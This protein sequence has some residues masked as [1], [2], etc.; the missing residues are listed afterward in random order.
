[1][2]PALALARKIS[3]LGDRSLK[4]NKTFQY[5]QTNLKLETLYML[6]D[7][8]HPY[9]TQSGNADFELLNFQLLTVLYWTAC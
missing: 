7:I 9:W 2:R 3:P 8:P 6:K 4:M 5:L 1:M